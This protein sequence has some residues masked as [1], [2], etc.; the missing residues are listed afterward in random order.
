MAIAKYKYYQMKIISFNI[1]LFSICLCAAIQ[2]TAQKSP[3]IIFILTDDQG[4]NHVSYHADPD[5]AAS[6]SDYF[7][8]PHMAAFAEAGMRFTDGYAPN[9][10]C[11]PTRHSVLFGQN[12]ARHIYNQNHDWYKTAQQKLT[13]PK[14]IKMANAE[15]RTAHFGKWHVALH[16]SLAGYDLHD[17]LTSNSAGEIFGHDIINAKEHNA[18]TNALLKANN[19]ANPLNLKQGK[20][21]LY[22]NEENPK[23]IF[24]IT[25]RGIEFMDR[26][27]ADAKPFYLQLSHYATHLSLS[28]RKETYQEFKNKPKGAVHESAEFGAMLKDLDAGI[29]MIINHL[30]EKGIADNTYIFIMGDNGGR[31]SLNKVAI[32]NNDKNIMD[33]FYPTT[34][35]RNEPLRDGK[36]SF[37]EGGLK[38]PFLVMGPDVASGRVSRTPVTGL[39]LLPTFY[40]LAGGQE[41]LENVDGGSIASLIHDVNVKNIDR[42]KKA[43]I[44]HQGSHRPPRSAIRVN[45]YKLIKYW[46]QENKY[47]N[48]PK[49]E[50]F[51]LREDPFE[52]NDLTIS[53]PDKTNELLSQLLEALEEYG[54]VTERT[55]VPTAIT[56]AW[57]EYGEQGRN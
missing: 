13:I 42:P 35:M 41:T 33:A 29:G 9:P 1:L 20:P 31:G 37:Y 3:N 32:M 6:K 55:N 39:D 26:C 47:A 19:A 43:L 52:K 38:V 21:T 49:V 54:G 5:L 46:S 11:A 36:H 57:Q 45:D 15:Y 56:R 12:A 34:N 10:I 25:K 24:G 28:A 4:W 16:P 23:D 51:Y 17:G 44:F 22:W 40:E 27:I 18:E 2:L 53:S 30:R 8:T 14:V 7:E 50:L 48:T